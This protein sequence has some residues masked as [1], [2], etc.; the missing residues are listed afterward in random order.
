[1]IP[2][3][4]GRISGTGVLAFKFIYVFHLCL[5]SR[6][7]PNGHPWNLEAEKNSL[8]VR[9][10]WHCHTRKRPR[11]G[12]PDSARRCNCKLA[13]RG[14]C[15]GEGWLRRLARGMCFGDEKR[16]LF[17]AADQWNDAFLSL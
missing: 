4:L 6:S 7:C 10:L 8:K 12:E 3:Y 2:R 1:M 17:L 11:E 5:V 15:F 13:W 14:M 16:S 9:C